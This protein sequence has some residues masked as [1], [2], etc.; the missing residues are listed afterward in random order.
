[1]SNRRAQRRRDFREA[2]SRMV[3]REPIPP[4]N[5]HFAPIH[6][7]GDVGCLTVS[8]FIRSWRE[9]RRE[10]RAARRN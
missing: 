9:V 3:V 7:Q 6:R 10:R 8:A 4:V 5:D 1:M 2:R